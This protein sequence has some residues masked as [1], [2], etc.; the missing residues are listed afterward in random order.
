MYSRFSS[1]LMR[2]TAVV[3]ITVGL[4][5][6]AGCGETSESSG[7][8]DPTPSSASAS[9]TTAAQDTEAALGAASWVD[10]QLE[11]NLMNGEYGADYGLSIDAALALAEVGGN[12]QTVTA[13]ADAVAAKVDSYTTGVDFGSKDVYSGAVAKAAVLAEVAGKDPRAFGGADLVARLEGLVA[14]A[15]A[16][17]GR[18]AD[19][20]TSKGGKDY[21]NVIGQVLAVRA[22]TAADSGEAGA[23]TEFLLEQQCSDGYFRLYFAKAKAAEQGCSDDDATGSAPDIDAT[24]IAVLSLSAGELDADT[25]QA[26]DQAVDWM[27]QQQEQD[28]S[29]AGTGSTA[30]PNANTTGLA[31]WALGTAGEDE[32][33][34]RAA[35]WL[36]GVQVAD[37][38]DNPK[39]A[40]SSGAVAY[41]EAALVAGQKK[42]IRPASLDQWR[43]ATVQAL[44]ALRWA[45]DTSGQ[46]C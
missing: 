41:D 15:G 13:I 20:V 26:V 39:L 24:A 43:R 18:V 27:L 33:A 9:P 1:P 34:T 45:G 30:G 28:G 35:D 46:A 8:S 6:L 19:E 3:A 2:A 31:G 12:E 40:D 5:G 44:P 16:T 4:S 38:C 22:L 32:A 17:G 14:D 7:S 37:Q 25:Q 36:A 29:L 21:A 10:G 42:G 23:A 11:K